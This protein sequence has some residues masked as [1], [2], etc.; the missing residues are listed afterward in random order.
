MNEQ[1]VRIEVGGAEV[2]RSA[3]TVREA[4]RSH[5]IPA[6]RDGRMVLVDLPALRAHF[7]PQPVVP[8]A[9]K[10]SRP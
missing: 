1:F 4:I 5:G 6:V 9:M 7:A 2:R 10:V 8:A 3:A